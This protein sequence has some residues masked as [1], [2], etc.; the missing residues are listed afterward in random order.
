MSKKN[1]PLHDKVEECR[2]MLSVA[3]DDTSLVAALNAIPLLMSDDNA[4]DFIC[5]IYD[6][7]SVEFM[8]RFLREDSEEGI[9]AALTILSR[10][11]SIEKL[12]N[13]KKFV[14]CFKDLLKCVEKI[15]G[16]YKPENA[17]V[18]SDGL[19]C[20]AVL[21]ESNSA[22][23]SSLDRMYC[24]FENIYD[25]MPNNIINCALNICEKKV[26]DGSYWSSAKANK[27]MKLIVGKMKADPKIMIENLSRFNSFFL[28]YG[29]F[30]RS[31]HSGHSTSATWISDVKV[32]IRKMLCNNLPESIRLEAVTAAGCLTNV[33]GIQWIVSNVKLFEA[34]L[35]M[36]TIEIQYL[37]EVALVNIPENF[38]CCMQACCQ[39]VFEVMM[40]LPL[41]EQWSLENADSF[42]R[43]TDYIRDLVLFTLH[44]L[45]EVKGNDRV[46]VPAKLIV[47][48]SNFLRF[49]PELVEKGLPVEILSLMVKYLEKA[50][51]RDEFAEAILCVFM[52]V[53]HLSD[54]E[55]G[56]SAA[57]LMRS[58]NMTLEW[59][60][61]VVKSKT[62]QDTVD[63][64]HSWMAT[65]FSSFLDVDMTKVEM[66]AD[67]HELPIS[68]QR[69]DEMLKCEQ[70]LRQE[71]I[72]VLALVAN[73][74]IHLVEGF[75]V[76][77]T[78]TQAQSLIDIFVAV[79]EYITGDNPL[80]L[81][82]HSMENL[83]QLLNTGMDHLC[84]LAEQHN[85]L[86][87]MLNTAWGEEEILKF[88]QQKQDTI[89]NIGTTE[90]RINRST[91][92]ETCR[93]PPTR[94]DCIRMVLFVSNIGVALN[95]SSFR[96]YRILFIIEICF[97]RRTFFTMN[98][99]H[100]NIQLRDQALLCKIC[101]KTFRDQVAK[102]NHMRMH[103]GQRPFVCPIC[104]RAFLWE[105]SFRGHLNAHARRLIITKSMANAI[106]EKEK[107][108]HQWKKKKPPKLGYR[109]TIYSKKSS[110]AKSE[111]IKQLF[112]FTS[113]F[114]SYTFSANERK[115]KDEETTITI[116][117]R[118]AKLTIVND[119]TRKNNSVPKIIKVRLGKPSTLK[120]EAYNHGELKGQQAYEFAHL[121]D[122]FK[123]AQIS[124]NERFQK[125]K[126]VH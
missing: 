63:L 31:N 69:V 20:L 45:T 109:H 66:D 94:A 27:I 124:M 1:I 113:H 119:N 112:V 51:K 105:I 41:H 56:I 34:V 70:I 3:N 97:Q 104:K 96:L 44:C 30:D 107:N 117:L 72:D 114:A 52:A 76:K 83:N 86:K 57:L 33:I 24:L 4:D 43:I 2:R 89:S 88:M 26:L 87:E 99:M 73:G 53:A 84:K 55:Y 121:K 75:R 40:W 74:Y 5:E 91:A 116:D 103:S 22:P 37:Y 12:P 19:F 90:R 17:E 125:M 62:D 47:I 81:D 39:F 98:P 35:A 18:L 123:R 64:V 101:Q 42:I 60:F 29:N 28:Q 85:K 92:P 48:V 15:A 118:N 126:K 54:G 67:V 13:S 100:V 23:N 11:L 95:G 10:L 8:Q 80:K 71:D 111:N 49:A 7:V 14:S 82:C 77:L 93:A 6:K 46:K 120:N 16:D 25:K 115:D 65:V 38:Q 9:V 110:Q 59:I 106:Y 50:E 79:K 32:M 61:L 102:Y 58:F 78:E 122:K 108:R 68:I 21:Y 36:C